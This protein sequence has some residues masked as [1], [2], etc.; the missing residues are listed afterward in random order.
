MIPKPAKILA[1]IN[2]EMKAIQRS[3][4]EP[5]AFIHSTRD[6][7]VSRSDFCFT[8]ELLALVPMLQIRHDL[9]VSE[10]EIGC[11]ISRR[12]R[13]ERFAFVGEFEI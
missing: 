6:S 3:S 8:Q 11:L 1:T 2:R 4:H 12:S 13:S 9:H 7:S 5:A 10:S